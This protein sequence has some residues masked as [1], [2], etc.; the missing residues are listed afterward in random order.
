MLLVL[1][2]N[3]ELETEKLMKEKEQ[4][5]RDNFK[6]VDRAKI[7]KKYKIEH[8]A[9]LVT[10]VSI[11]IKRLDTSDKP[12]KRKEDHNEVVKD[13]L[14]EERHL[15]PIKKNDRADRHGGGGHHPRQ[16]EQAKS[17]PDWSE[18]WVRRKESTGN[19]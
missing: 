17:P 5:L 10:A 9:S 15:A 3:K 14:P 18:R 2:Y 11:A 8:G 13:Q 19:R 4:K 7:T 1:S 6:G 12:T 16:G